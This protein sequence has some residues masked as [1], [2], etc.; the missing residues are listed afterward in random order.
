[1]EV[2]STRHVFATFLE[3]CASDVNRQ[4]HSCHRSHWLGPVQLA[5]L[6]NVVCPSAL[7]NHSSKA[8]I[9]NSYWGSRWS[10][11]LKRRPNRNGGLI[12]PDKTGLW[13]AAITRAKY[14]RHDMPYHGKPTTLT[15]LV[16]DSIY[17]FWFHAGWDMQQGQGKQL[18]FF[19]IYV[20]S[21]PI[22]WDGGAFQLARTT[23]DI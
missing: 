15:A 4:L 18:C 8:S 11:S 2:L 12:I 1:M 9:R 10:S 16:L 3:F 23:V 5:V 13:D 19:S 7:F 6:N 17:Q 14:K 22:K 20:I 21:F